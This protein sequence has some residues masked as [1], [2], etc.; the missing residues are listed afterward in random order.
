[1]RR[2]CSD[3]LLTAGQSDG[4][5]GSDKGFDRVAVEIFD[6]DLL[7][8]STLHDACDAHGVVTVAFVD[9]QL[10]SRLRMPG[11]VGPRAPNCFHSIASLTMRRPW[12]LVESIY[13]RQAMIHCRIDE[14]ISVPVRERAGRAEKSFRNFTEMRAWHQKIMKRIC[15]GTPDWSEGS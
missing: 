15:E 3:S 8:P 10:Q 11:I 14:P 6:A 5:F 12:P 7:I 13:R 1:M 4:V 9:L 2:S